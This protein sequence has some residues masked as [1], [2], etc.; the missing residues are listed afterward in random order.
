MVGSHG[1]RFKIFGVG[2]DCPEPFICFQEFFQTNLKLIPKIRLQ[3]LYSM[4]LL[5]HL[6]V[7]KFLVSVVTEKPAEMR[8]W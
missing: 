2:G 7:L 1:P 8:F 6:V 4:S 5:F 3:C